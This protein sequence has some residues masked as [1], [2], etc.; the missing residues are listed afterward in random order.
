MTP[1]TQIRVTLTLAAIRL[2]REYGLIAPGLPLSTRRMETIS[3][4]IGEPV[5]E[6]TFRRIESSALA[7]LRHCPL[8]LA[9]W[10]ASAASSPTD[11]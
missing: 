1:E 10:Q 8:A 6:R 7:K 4:E 11:H 9:A 2:R 3:I 5:S